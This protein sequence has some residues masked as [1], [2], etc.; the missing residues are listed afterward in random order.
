MTTPAVITTPASA[1]APWSRTRRESATT[2][3]AIATTARTTPNVVTT[4]APVGR[5]HDHAARIPSAL[6]PAPRPQPTRRR[7]ATPRTSRA[8]TTAGTIRYENTSRTPA[9]LT[10]LV[11]TSPNDV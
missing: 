7:C 11:T 6:T 3:S 8:P 4:A 9:S 1:R 10:E 2:P 5:S